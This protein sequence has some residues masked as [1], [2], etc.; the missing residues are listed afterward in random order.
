[1]G[2][3]SPLDISVFLN[4]LTD[5]AGVKDMV[6][7]LA[8]CV[9]IVMSFIL[10]WFGVRKAY[11]IFVSAVIGKRIEKGLADFDDYWTDGK[12]WYRY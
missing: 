2:S 6:T 7:L 9:G 4:A 8:S 1:M 5:L 12:H 3:S 11:T 10:L